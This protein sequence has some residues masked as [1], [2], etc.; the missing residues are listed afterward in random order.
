MSFRVNHRREFG[1]LLDHLGLFG[2]AVE[3]G[4]HRGDFAYQFL[5]GWPSGKLICV[6]P[7][8]SQLEGYFEF[9][10]CDR[11][12]DFLACQDKLAEFGDRVSFMRMVS[13]EAAKLIPDR[14]LS[15]VYIDANHEYPFVRQDLQL[16][17]PKIVR[18][19][20]FAGHDWY[21]NRENNTFWLDV[22]KAVT[23]FA[24]E[25]GLP[26]TLVPGDD[27]QPECELGISPSWYLLVP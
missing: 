22:Q 16:W 24:S 14:S 3:V 7:W 12:L 19:G 1:G 11:E 10:D 13:S 6:D 25:I 4:T 21:I 2:T 23:E 20:V 15:M 17:W 9:T 8:Q 18:G 26:V 27:P 5:T